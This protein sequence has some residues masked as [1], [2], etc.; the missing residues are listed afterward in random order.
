MLRVNL[1]PKLV[2]SDTPKPGLY[3]QT[4]T[5]KNLDL[6]CVYFLANPHHLSSRCADFENSTFLC[7]LGPRARTT[8]TGACIFRLPT[9]TFN[10]CQTEGRQ[11]IKNNRIFT[12]SMLSTQYM[13][14][15][16]QLF[17]VLVKI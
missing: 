1:M 14:A 16:I 2:A 6:L 11:L 17:L 12:Q 10:E 8:L 3:M 5:P 4:Y 9:Q 7:V 13:A 15:I